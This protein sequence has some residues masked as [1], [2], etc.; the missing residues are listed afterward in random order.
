LV[1]RQIL[2]KTACGESMDSATNSR[3][4]ILASSVE[5]DLYKTRRYLCKSEV[6]AFIGLKIVVVR[7]NR[8]RYF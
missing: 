8:K 7:K 4:G 2:D 6:F 5:K 1:L 3:L